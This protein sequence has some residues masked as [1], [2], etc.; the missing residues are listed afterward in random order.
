MRRYEDNASLRLDILGELPTNIKEYVP[1]Y[2]G[3][4]VFTQKTGGELA[5]FKNPETFQA[6]KEAV[7]RKGPKSILRKQAPGGGRPQ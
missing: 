1:K 6:T 7:A 2:K 3:L 5:I 4:M